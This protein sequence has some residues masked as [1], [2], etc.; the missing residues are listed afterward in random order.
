MNEP[1]PQEAAAALRAVHEAREQVITAAAAPRWLWIAG[2]LLVFLY[3][4]ANDLF[5]AARIWPWAAGAL[6]LVLALGLRTRAGSVVLGRPVATSD[7]SMSV[8]F[9]R[10][11]LRLAPVLGLGIA[12]ALI[13][14]FHVP[15]GGI[16][17]G[18]PAGL[19]V[20][21]VGPRLRLWL[22]R[23]REKD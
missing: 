1:T 6:V 11:V 12:A 9:R 7:R 14:Q 4:A 16:Y 21:I 2:G 17:Y 15:H 3:C 19:F 18:A 13:V 20:M 8:T 5:P 22:L 10:R 23:Q